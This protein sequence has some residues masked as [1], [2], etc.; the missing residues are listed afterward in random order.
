MRR[1]FLVALGAIVIVAVVV[2]MWWLPSYREAEL[3]N[4][5]ATIEKMENLTARKDAALSLS[6]V[7]GLP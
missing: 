7:V 4:E 6:A 2:F 5:I 1:G 3:Q